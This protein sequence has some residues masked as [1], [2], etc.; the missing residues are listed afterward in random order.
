METL[1]QP[2][3]PTSTP[4]VGFTD[5]MDANLSSSSL[6]EKTVSPNSVSFHEIDYDNLS[7]VEDSAPSVSGDAA[8]IPEEDFDSPPSTQSVRIPFLLQ[9]LRQHMV[10]ALSEVY[11]ADFSHM[12]IYGVVHS[13]SHRA[14][15]TSCNDE[16]LL[17]EYHKL[18]IMT[19]LSLTDF[20]DYLLV[21]MPLLSGVYDSSVGAISLYKI[22]HCQLEFIRNRHAMIQQIRDSVLKGQTESDLDDLAHLNKA[23]SE[24]MSILTHLAKNTLEED[25]TQLYNMELSVCSN[26]RVENEFFERALRN[27]E[28]FR[29][30]EA[31]AGQYGYCKLDSI[32]CGQSSEFESSGMPNEKSCDDSSTTAP[33]SQIRSGSCDNSQSTDEFNDLSSISAFSGYECDFP[34]MVLTD[35]RDAWQVVWKEEGCLI[36]RNF[37]FEEFGYV[38]AE[39][40]AREFLD[41]FSDIGINAARKDVNSSTYSKYRNGRKGTVQHS[42]LPRNPM[43]PGQ[44]T[45]AYTKQSHIFE[46][47]EEDNL[48][49]FEISSEKTF[50]GKISSKGDQAKA[51]HFATCDESGLQV[52]ENRIALT[53][54]NDSPPD[55]I[56]KFDSARQGWL[57]CNTAKQG[58][59][60][61]KFFS[62]AKY[63][64][65]KA[66]NLAQS[67]KKL[68]ARQSHKRTSFGKREMKTNAVKRLPGRPRGS[69][70]TKQIQKVKPGKEIKPLV[71]TPK[72]ALNEKGPPGGMANLSKASAGILYRQD[73]ST[74]RIERLSLRAMEFPYVHGVAF[75]A[76]NFAWL[77][78]VGDDTRR[79]LVKKY[80]WEKARM[81]AVERVEER[82]KLLD[83][84]KLAKEIEKEQ[85]VLVTLSAI[86]SD[87][88]TKSAHRDVQAS[89]SLDEP[90]ASSESNMNPVKF[91]QTG[92]S[93]GEVR[94]LP[95]NT[96]PWMHLPANEP[97]TNAMRGIRVKRKHTMIEGNA[98]SDDEGVTEMHTKFGKVGE[99]VFQLFKNSSEE[100]RSKDLESSPN[101][102]NRQNQSS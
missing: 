42:R 82:R 3:F 19:T 90:P 78:T 94:S 70:V 21:L 96:T 81:C 87:T 56:M 46:E 61:S 67:W 47:M 57:C 52:I 86:S 91:E 55:F 6:T 40:A 37:S 73:S 76:E 14:T 11:P 20:R 83:P 49:P 74:T 59:T 41:E 72:V 85:Q 60:H 22:I 51:M 62:C 80:G 16:E 69:G 10:A 45:K 95:V 84:E 28:L 88:M 24:N 34:R 18:K 99:G 17:F 9:S 39:E 31:S 15:V 38:G 32:N 92:E 8:L 98:Y 30:S 7:H 26:H 77:A 64:Y 50:M 25:S 29:L 36:K 101:V 66:L 89:P 12:D 71:Y 63:G 65:E 1:F 54:N 53:S 35:S 97:A 93:H 27:D 4:S 13:P 75:E 43:Y 48:I 58:T 2:N 23:Q 100:C 44:R 5:R 68:A 79:Y 33:P 102:Y